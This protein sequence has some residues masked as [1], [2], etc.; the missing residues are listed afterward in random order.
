MPVA[1]A[2]NPEARAG[3]VTEGA[4]LRLVDRAGRGLAF[5]IVDG[6]L[7]AGPVLL[8]GR[9]PTDLSAQPGAIRALLAE[10][11]GGGLS[12]TATEVAARVADHI[13]D[14]GGW[15]PTGPRRRNLV[16]VLLGGAFPLAGSAMTL[17]AGP[18]DELPRW[19][20]PA[21][22]ERTAADAARIAFGTRATRPVVAAL[23][24]SLVPSPTTAGPG[25][26]AEQGP[27]PNPSG[28]PSIAL[29]PLALACMAAD[30][31]EPDRLAVV[32]RATDHHHPPP[33]WPRND[34][35]ALVRATAPSL[36]A[37]RLERMLV[38]AAATADGPVRLVET[39][40][41][42]RSVHQLLHGRI[43]TRLA[44]VADCCRAAMPTDPVDRPSLVRGWSPPSRGAPRLGPRSTG[45]VGAPPRPRRAPTAVRGPIGRPLIAE[46]GPAPPA[47]APHHQ[48]RV[49][50]PGLDLPMAPTEVI[51]RDAATRAIDGLDTGGYTLRVPRTGRDLQSWGERMGNCLA[52]YT[53]AAM[54]GRSTIVGVFSDHRIVACME[55]DPSQRVRQFVG[56]ANTPPDPALEAEV[57]G[58]L[59]R[60]GVVAPQPVGSTAAR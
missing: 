52:T 36:G 42:W 19:A 55:I 25:D 8:A 12:V 50:P 27:E 2:S 18:V 45:A 5:D 58:T 11:A 46:P 4:R 30:A 3:W 39:V 49:P 44:D 54:A 41:M 22:R 21:L 53:S 23:A 9:A 32:L 40:R 17:G 59:R 47:R 7:R 48:P 15:T 14:H 26:R 29:M 24:R 16:T 1:P 20:V 43:P 56:R 37:T 35:V 34:D 31:L 57:L 10:Q 13:D 33:S 6:R 28:L 51:P 60:H 38:D